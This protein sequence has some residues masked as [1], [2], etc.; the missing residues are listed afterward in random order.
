ME[1][2]AHGGRE[3]ECLERGLVI[4]AVDWFAILI[5]TEALRQFQRLSY[6]RQR[7]LLGYTR[8][9]SYDIIELGEVTTLNHSIRLVQHKELDALNLASYFVVLTGGT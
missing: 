9:E 1:L 2:L 8:R 3:D 7:Y 4:L 6:D 5:K